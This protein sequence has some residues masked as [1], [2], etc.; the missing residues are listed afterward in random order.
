MDPPDGTP[1]KPPVL[2]EPAARLSSGT[3]RWAWIV[4]AHAGVILTAALLFHL[5]R[6]APGA[7]VAGAL[8]ET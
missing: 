8:I 4:G 1:S 2:P 6:G 3:I 5:I 7:L